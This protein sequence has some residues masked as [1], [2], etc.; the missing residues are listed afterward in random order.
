[1]K[2]LI[3]WTVLL[4]GSVAILAVLGLVFSLYWY[5]KPGALET[6]VTV[7]IPPGTGF[8]GVTALLDEHGVINNQNLFIVGTVL[9]GAQSQIKAGEYKFAAHISPSQVIEKLVK[10]DSVIHALTIPEGLT[11]N[12]IVTL[13]AQDPRMKGKITEGIEDGVLMP[14][15]YH[16]HRGDQRAELIKRMKTEMQKTLDELWEK[17]DEGLPFGSRSEALVLASIVEK[18]TGVDSER[19]QVASVFINRLRKDMP[20]QSDPTVVYGVEKAEGPMNRELLRKDLLTDS[21]YNTYMHKGLPPGPIANP[22]RASIEAVL[23]PD[24]TDYYYFVATGRGGHYFSETLSE[25]NQN[26]L[27]YKAELSAQ[28]QR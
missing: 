26:V 3:K 6:E 5:A 25:H 8:K 13:I 1:M 20:L 17:R 10:G 14:D 2:Q 28:R 16:F 7:E 4:V 27:R 12:A 11:S 21:P 9:Q 18:E 19:K 22:G 15:T 24:K 23:N